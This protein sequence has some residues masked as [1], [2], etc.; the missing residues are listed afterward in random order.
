MAAVAAGLRCTTTNNAYTTPELAHQYTDSRAKL[1]ITT[2]DGIKTVRAMF[3]ELGVSRR[4]GDKRTI[5]VGPD[6]RW[7]GGPS[8]KPSPDAAGLLTME[9]LLKGGKLDQEEKF[10]GPLSN[11]TAYLCYS[12]GTTG[13]PKASLLTLCSRLRL[14]A[15]ITGSRGFILSLIHAFQVDLGT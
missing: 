6:L 7:A 14:T 8:A 12:S 5:V 2:E 15:I 13:K 4:D 11:E 1:V 9:D 10:D 3:A